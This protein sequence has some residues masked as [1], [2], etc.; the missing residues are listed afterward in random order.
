VLAGSAERSPEGLP[1]GAYTLVDEPERDL[2]LVLIGTGS[3]VAVCVAAAETLAAE[4]IGARV[5]SMPS[6]DL[7]AAQ[8]DEYRAEVLPT[9]IPRLAVEAGSTFGWERYA[10]AVVGFDHFGSSA[11]GDRVLTEFGINPANV[12]DH[13][14]ALVAGASR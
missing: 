11:P 9:G 4:G 5:V 1:R 10:D 6:W 14:R 13:A 2:D 12:T 8:P 7:F 3:E